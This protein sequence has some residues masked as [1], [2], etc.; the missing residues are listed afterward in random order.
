MAIICKYIKMPK[1]SF[2]KILIVL[3]ELFSEY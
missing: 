1:L 2:G 3:K